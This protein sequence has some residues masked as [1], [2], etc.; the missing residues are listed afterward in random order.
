MC[1]CSKHYLLQVPQHRQRN[2][3]P[4]PLSLLLYTDV[5]RKIRSRNRN[6]YNKKEVKGSDKASILEV[7]KRTHRSHH[8]HAAAQVA[9]MHMMQLQV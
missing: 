4:P 1:V 3:L 5:N 8:T 2:T 7:G 6:A 9:N